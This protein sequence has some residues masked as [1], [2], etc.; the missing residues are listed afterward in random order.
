MFKSL[1]CTRLLFENVFIINDSYLSI[2]IWFK[3][4]SVALTFFKEN[5]D[6]LNKAAVRGEEPLCFPKAPLEISTHWHLCFYHQHRL[7][8]LLLWKS[9]ASFTQVHLCFPHVKTSIYMN[10]IRNRTVDYYILIKAELKKYIPKCLRQ[11][12]TFIRSYTSW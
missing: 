4:N 3:S 8:L 6:L 2:N 12:G 9:N 5:S 10:L 11:A 7:L 1:I